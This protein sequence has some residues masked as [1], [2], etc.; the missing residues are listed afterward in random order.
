M[1]L[2]L[3]LAA[4]LALPAPALTEPPTPPDIPLSDPVAEAK[5]QRVMA[6]LRCLTCQN[7]AISDSGAAQAQAMRQEVRAQVA[8]GRSDD[9]VR[10]WFVERYGDWVSLRPPAR[11]DTFLLWAAPLLLV[12]AGLW[13]VAQRF[14]R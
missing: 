5:A 10:G 6:E 14:R 2:F 12:A 8:A 1:R 9:E 11:G 4:L 3:I 7:Q 13:A